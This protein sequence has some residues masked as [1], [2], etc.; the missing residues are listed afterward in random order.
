MNK[1]DET[2]ETSGIEILWPDIN[3]K[4]FK[5]E[6]AHAESGYSPN[7][8]S[9]IVQYRVKNG[10]TFLWMGDLETITLGVIEPHINIPKIDILFAPHHGRE[11]GKVPALMLSK[12]DP[13]IVVIGE[14]PSE[15]LN[16][17]EGYNTITQNTAGD[18]VFDCQTGKVHV[19]TSNEYFTDFLEDEEQV[20]EGYHYA[21][22]LNLA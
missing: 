15:H 19:F 8:I 13:K 7:N 10:S 6:L 3:N 2:R 17:Y 11:S 16:Y 22:T 18:I 20:R 1:S 9:A 14:A 21:G 4:L 5:E 12:M